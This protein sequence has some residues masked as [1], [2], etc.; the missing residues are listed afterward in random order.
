MSMP[1]A[2]RASSSGSLKC[3]AQDEWHSH[4]SGTPLNGRP[5]YSAYDGSTPFGTLRNRS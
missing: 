4:G 5:T 2:W 3:S 1:I